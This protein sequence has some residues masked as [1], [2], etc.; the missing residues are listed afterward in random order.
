VATWWTS[1]LELDDDQAAF[2]DGD[3]DQSILLT[4]PPGSGKTNLLLLRAASLIRQGVQSLAILSFTKTLRSF[5]LTA[6]LNYRVPERHIKTY[7]RWALRLLHERVP[8]FQS[9]T[10]SFE[11]VRE[12][13]R[14]ALEAYTSST[15]VAPLD[16]LFLDEGQD[17][18]P[19]EV[20]VLRKLCRRL[21]VTADDRQQIYQDRAT[22]ERLQSV[23]DR[24]V[25][26]TYH[27]RNARP[28]VR[29]AD[30]ILGLVGMPDSLEASC[31]YTG[32][33]ATVRVESDGDSASQAAAIVPQIT[34]Q[35]RLY[36]G[37]PIG[38]LVPRSEDEEAVWNVLHTSPIQN[39]VQLRLREDDEL[40][41]ERPVVVSTIHSAK[42]LEFRV[43]YLLVADRIVKFRE[44]AS[45]L[46]FTAVTRAK[47][48]LYVYHERALP[49]YLEQGLRDHRVLAA[50]TRWTDL[51]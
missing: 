49:D 36:E 20:T 5:I 6:P 42:G 1:P 24:H 23:V 27:Y 30:S 43:V 14:A 40:D 45:R 39:H 21:I 51:F 25:V 46:A 19:A 47:T 34:E 32:P 29:V 38:V 41:L 50:R 28:I 22:L 48:G 9:P 35:L 37:D 31:H 13:I 12:S 16:Y 11:E 7:H 10:G 18:L 17:Y 4:G 2:V 26:L 44:R 8:G 15:N 3:L 33:A